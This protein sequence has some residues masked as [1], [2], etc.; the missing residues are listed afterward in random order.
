M[1]KRGIKDPA[2][3]LK[4]ENGGREKGK[5]GGRRETEVTNKNWS[6]LSPL[7]S[8]LLQSYW[9]KRVEMNDQPGIGTGTLLGSKIE[10]RD[11]KRDLIPSDFF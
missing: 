9:A 11:D 2:F 8:S 10:R 6:V 3:A 5:E 7:K 4:G 1:G